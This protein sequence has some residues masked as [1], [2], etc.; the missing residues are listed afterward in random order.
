MSTISLDLPEEHPCGSAPLKG[1]EDFVGVSSPMQNV[2][3][4]LTQVGPSSA[5]VLLVGESGTGKELA[6]KTLHRLSER[7]REAFVA[8]NCAAIPETLI[9]SELFGHEKGAFTGATSLR[10][11]WFEIANAGTLFLDE[12]G[13]MP[14]GSQVK[15]LRALEERCIR[16]LRGTEEIRVDVRIVAALGEPPELAVEQGRIRS[17]LLYRINVFTIALPP[18]R[19][20][21]SDIVALAEHFVDQF[22][23]DN[24]KPT[25]KLD[26]K[27]ARRLTLNDWPGNVRELRNTMER[28]VILTRGPWIRPD[29][30]P[31]ATAG[32]LVPAR[33]PLDLDPEDCRVRVGTTIEE[34]SRVLTLKTLTAT[35]YNKTEAARMLGVSPRT[36]YNKLKEW[37]ASGDAE[38][39]EADRRA[40]GGRA[41]V[42]PPPSAKEGRLVSIRSGRASRIG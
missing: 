24:G 22:A 38:A 27:A 2:Y 1:F 11:G 20:R 25:P 34:A 7:R 28:A 14:L 26:E 37:S 12:L 17:D 31:P 21:A 35:G 13:A 3:R 30:L 4:M 36:V 41:Q 33:T 32:G 5:S 9:E 23:L 8:L 18:L 10:R 39:A 40:S 19:E 42:P 16:R 29:D 15:L 6:A